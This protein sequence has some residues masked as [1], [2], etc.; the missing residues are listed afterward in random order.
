MAAVAEIGNIPGSGG[1]CVNQHFSTGFANHITKSAGSGELLYN[2][3]WVKAMYPQAR[4]ASRI[5]MEDRW[6]KRLA[7]AR[8]EHERAVE[9]FRHAAEIY[10]VQEVPFPD[11]GLALH[12]AIAAESLTRKE[13][14]RVLRLFTDLILNGQSPPEEVSNGRLG[15]N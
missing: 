2:I 11:G 10:R 14:I 1:L 9:Q 7:D 13:Y 5:D 15:G 12:R 3:R 6:H 8:R 4:S